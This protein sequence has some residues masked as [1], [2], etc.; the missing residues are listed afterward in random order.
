MLPQNKTKECMEAKTIFLKI[1]RKGRKMCFLMKLF[2]A[3]CDEVTVRNSCV[4][5]HA[6][7]DPVS[8]DYG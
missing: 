5:H 4:I 1:R 7:N 8:V 6:L 3:A 2:Y